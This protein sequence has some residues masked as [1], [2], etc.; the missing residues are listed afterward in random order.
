[1][2]LMSESEQTTSVYRLVDRQGQVIDVQ[3]LPTDGEALAWA[4]EVRRRQVP[5]VWIRRVERQAGDDWVFVSP[6]GE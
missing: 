6:S 4:E 5:R 1:M 3:K 2:S